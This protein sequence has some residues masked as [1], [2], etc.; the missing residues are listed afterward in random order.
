MAGPKKEGLALLL[1]PEK[2]GEGGDDDADE[3]TAASEY[4]DAATDI[5]DLL[6]VPAEK[7]EAFGLALK[8]FVMSCMDEE[9]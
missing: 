8:R 3:T 6:D 1:S 9:A 2:P 5:A 4:D 7:R